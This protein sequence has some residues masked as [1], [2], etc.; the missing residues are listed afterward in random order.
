MKNWK[1]IMS[2][3]VTIGIVIAFVTCDNGKNDPV[4]ICDWGNWVI[5]VFPD[6]DSPG[7]ETKICKIDAS[8]IETRS[9]DLETFKTYFYGTWKWINPDDSNEWQQMVI[10]ETTFH[11][12]SSTAVDNRVGNITL[13]LMEPNHDDNKDDYPLGYQIYYNDE[14][15]IFI[16]YIHANKESIFRYNQGRIHIKQ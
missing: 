16:G 4:H 2:V 10:T 3:L 15:N 5:T 13:W 1:F 9:L 14:N 8:H 12:H 6:E 7:E 11:I